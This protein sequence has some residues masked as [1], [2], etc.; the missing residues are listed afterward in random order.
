MCPKFKQWLLEQGYWSYQY[1]GDP[2][3]SEYM[4]I[5]NK[6]ITYK[7]GYYMLNEDLKSKRF[8]SKIQCTQN[9]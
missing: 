9:S 6:Y 3:N 2:I 4:F 8:I 5:I 1:V 7:F